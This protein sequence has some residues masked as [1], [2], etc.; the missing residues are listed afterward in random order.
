L[1][2]VF[3]LG[4][5]FFGRAF[6]NFPSQPQACR[7][8]RAV[9]LVWPGARVAAGMAARVR[10]R[11]AG[12]MRAHAAVEGPQ[13]AS[14]DGDGPRRPRRSA[15]GA[16]QPGCKLVTAPGGVLQLRLQGVRGS[17]P[18]SV[19]E[20]GQTPLSGRGRPAVARDLVGVDPWEVG[21]GPLCWDVKAKPRLR[22]VQSWPAPLL[23]AT[24]SP[25]RIS[26]P[27]PTSGEKYA[28]AVP[29]GAVPLTRRRAGCGAGPGGG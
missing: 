23:R 20:T 7:G 13:V 26:F 29:G 19:R 1:W 28:A 5:E 10:P 22:P 25:P 3:P 11:S 2:A 6:R 8:P 14:R 9:W 27:L 15:V 12:P 18:E 21:H 16:Q 4:E 24:R 17:Q